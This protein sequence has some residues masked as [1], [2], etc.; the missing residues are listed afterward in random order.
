MSQKKYT[1]GGKDYFF[2]EKYTLKDWGMI[3]KIISSI[4]L[5]N[6]IN[7]LVALLEGD[8]M[9]KLLNIILDKPLEGEIYE[10]DF[11]EVSRVIN[12]F[13]TRKKSL[14]KNTKTSSPSST[15]NMSMRQE[16]SKTSP[17]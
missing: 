1:I 8:S 7:M 9:V 10:D 17:E 15:E 2:K 12:H 13:F 3:M 11:E 16:S 6:N 14:M 5:K 4:D